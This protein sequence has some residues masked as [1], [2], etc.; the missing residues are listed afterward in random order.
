MLASFDFI[1]CFG[2]LQHTPRP[3]EAFLELVRYLRPG[4]EIAIDIYKRETGISKLRSKY[5]YRNLTLRVPP[6]MLMQLFQWYLP[7]WMPADNFLTKIP[8]VGNYLSIPI[9]CWN[10][11]NLPIDRKLQIEWTVLDTFDAFSAQY[12]QPQSINVVQLWF[13]QAGLINVDVRPGGNGI[14][15]NARQP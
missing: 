7:F 2:V 3:R 4:G 13:E 14:V 6:K 9:P 10:K 15:G 5:W 1:F 8:L 11:S 12:D